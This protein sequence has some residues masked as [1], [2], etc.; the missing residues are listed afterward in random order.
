MRM[1]EERKV[2]VKQ[3][4]GCRGSAAVVG[5]RW[6][7]RLQTVKGSRTG[8]VGGVRQARSSLRWGVRACDSLPVSTG[9]ARGASGKEEARGPQTVCCAGP[10]CVQECGRA[11]ACRRVREAEWALALTQQALGSA[12][13]GTRGNRDASRSVLTWAS[14]GRRA[15]RPLCW[16]PASST[17]PA[18]AGHQHAPRRPHRTLM[19]PAHVPAC[20]NDAPVMLT[21]GA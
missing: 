3:R 11:A 1:R 2:S 19:V 16:W 5:Q 20:C 8:G 12:A 14:A 17:G 9:A 6:S 21:C 15:P 18:P 4:A 7:G 10:T 13:P